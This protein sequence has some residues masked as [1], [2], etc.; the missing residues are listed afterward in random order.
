MRTLACA[1]ALP[2]TGKERVMERRRFK[3]TIP[4]DQRLDAE[5]KRLRKEAQGTPPSIERETLIRR[6]RE[7]ETAF[8][9][10]QWLKSP[11]LRSPIK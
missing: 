11:S 7:A 5:T 2:E 10:Q 8:H 6:A 1:P 4:L 9:M 3:Q